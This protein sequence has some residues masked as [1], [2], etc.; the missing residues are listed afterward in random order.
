MCAFMTVSVDRRPLRPNIRMVD[1]FGEGRVFVAGG[2]ARHAEHVWKLTKCHNR[3][4][5]RS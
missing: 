4:C 3:C 5:S 2:N 1:K